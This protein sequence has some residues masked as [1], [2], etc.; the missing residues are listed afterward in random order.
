M[1]SCIF[2]SC[3]T[4]LVKVVYFIPFLDFVLPLLLLPPLRRLLLLLLHLFP[5]GTSSSCVLSSFNSFGMHVKL[6]C[7]VSFLPPLGRVVR[8]FPVLSLSSFAYFCASF[9][10]SF[11]FSTLS[12][13][14]STFFLLRFAAF[15]DFLLSPRAMFVR[16][17]L[18]SFRTVSLFRNIFRKNW[19]W[20]K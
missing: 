18:S 6:F 1:L 15:C 3:S 5:L 2:T 17:E 4:S 10:R 7:F 16:N 9:A 14:L 19:E 20:K 12:R 11:S 13:C 8:F